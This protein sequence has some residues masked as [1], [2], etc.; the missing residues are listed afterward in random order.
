[1]NK[2]I[3]K[4]ALIGATSNPSKYGNIIFNDL[5]SK[6]YDVIPVHPALTE[7]Q[8]EKVW[9]N[10]DEIPGNIDLYIFVVPWKSG[11]ET[12]KKLVKSGKKKFW[13]QP[14]AWA[15]VIGEYLEKLEDIKFSY[16]ECIMVR[17]KKAGDLRF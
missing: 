6:G 17:S 10:I 9:N 3:R 11:F 15:P 2:V 13:F 8:G 12:L 1:M 14:G 5:K 4:V 7:L 16:N